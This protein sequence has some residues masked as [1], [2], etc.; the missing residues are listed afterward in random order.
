MHWKEDYLAP[1]ARHILLTCALVATIAA[2]TALV[3]PSVAR[4]VTL[5]EVTEQI[6][7]V[8]EQI[9][10]NNE[11]VE[12]AAAA[13]EEANAALEEANAVLAEAQAR[14]DE[15]QVQI[16][17]N[18][19]RIAEIEAALP[20][21]RE[22]AANSLV[23]LYKLSQDA[24]GLVDL[25]LS[26]E[27]FY[28]LLATLTYLDIIQTRNNE[29]VNELIELNNELE[30][31]RAILNGQMEEAAERR[32]EAADAQQAAADAQQAAED[33]QQAAET[34]LAESIALR[35]ELERQAA[36]I[37]AA[38]EAARQAAILEAQQAAAASAT[39][40]TESGEEVTVAV[41]PAST[42]LSAIDWTVGQ[43]AFIS[44]WGSRIDAYL[45]GSPLAG[46]GTTFAAAAWA[47]GVDPRLSPAISNTESSKGMHCFLPYNA[48]G[49]GQ[50]SWGD[51]ESAI[52]G[53]VGGLAAGGYYTITLAGAY[54]YC[55]P[56]A[57]RWY[58]VTLAQ[59]QMI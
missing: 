38:E 45:A 31:T 59:M 15:I 23:A 55:P 5:D 43:D 52:W 27:S 34:A 19:A 8:S 40:T 14:V 44:T 50:A 48:W 16:D 41:V 46:Y 49:W 35:E 22:K 2:G 47:N 6:T 7:E 18:E 42:G 25:V 28:E 20:G 54:R 58:A 56:N 11:R 13:V 37:A 30:Q 26:S 9:Q 21:Q 24:P 36:E 17:E 51:W 12:A 39:F 53:H 32:Q 1:K 33:A 57:A 10:E 4:A 29:A 3:H